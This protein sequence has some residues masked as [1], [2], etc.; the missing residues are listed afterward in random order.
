MES[1]YS[2]TPK[3]GAVKDSVHNGSISGMMKQ[4][5]F[6]SLTSASFVHGWKDIGAAFGGVFPDSPAMGGGR[7]A[8]GHGDAFHPLRMS[9]RVVGVA[10]RQGKQSAS[11]LAGRRRF[12]RHGEARNREI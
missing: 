10:E 12:T 7:R 5:P 1:V 9:W 6:I 2:L 4:E 8:R 11:P 3:L